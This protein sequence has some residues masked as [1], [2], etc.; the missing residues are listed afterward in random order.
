MNHQEIIPNLFRT[1]YSRLV[2]VLC[3]FYGLSNIQVAEDIVSETFYQA[4]TTWGQ[5]GIPDNQVGWLRT[6]AVNKTRDLQRRNKL[7][8]EK[9]IPEVQ[10]GQGE[11]TELEINLEVIKDSQL[12][13][14]FAICHPDLNIESHLSL[15]LRILCGFG[16]DEIASALLTNKSNINK[17]LFRSK[18]K[19]QE[20][21]INLEL[22]TPSELKDRLDVVLRIIYLIFNEG[23][24]SLTSDTPIN[25]E[26]CL[27]AMRLNLLLLE[28]P[29]F[30]L[31]KVNALMALLCFHSSRLDARIN[32]EGETILYHD[33]NP[34]LW[35]QELIKRGQF[36][37]NQAAVGNQISKYHI[38]AAIAFLHTQNSNDR[39]ESVLQLYNKLLTKEYS[40]AAAMNR[41]YALAM[42]N[43]LEEAITEAHKLKLDNNHLYFSLLAELYKM[44]GDF[45]SEKRYLV[46]AIELA[47]TE[48]DRKI[49]KAKLSDN[50]K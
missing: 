36:Y 9:I 29:M 34:D 32:P 33:Q 7:K 42:A 35:N 8:V 41:T 21:N 43:S 25:R 17:R 23:Y 20:L 22:P 16:I 4:M 39:W 1:E 15:A 6:V 50:V 47:K 26:L 19:L 27:E 12:K 24:Y 44:K 49:L 45:N 48:N 13:M 5:K 10:R 38:E 28:K 2:A 11:T 3:Q 46:Q 14:I 40:P 18:K 30:K 37:I 31:P